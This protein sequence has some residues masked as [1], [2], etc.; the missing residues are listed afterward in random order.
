MS[1]LWGPIG[2]GVVFV[3]GVAFEM[4]TKLPDNAVCA[5]IN[6]AVRQMFNPPFG[7]V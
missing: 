5:E 3:V 1:V 6:A 7:L 4:A 2:P